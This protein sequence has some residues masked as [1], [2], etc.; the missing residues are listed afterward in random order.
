MPGEPLRRLCERAAEL[1]VPLLAQWEVTQR[2]NLGCRHCYLRGDAEGGELSTAEAVE[3]F[4]QMA[5]VGV[6]FLTFT[7]GEPLLRPDLFE[8]V[9]EARSLG[10]AWKLL[11][12][13][14]LVDDVTAR[15]I[16]ERAPHGVSVSLYGLEDA[17]DWMTTVPGSFRDTVGAIKR[18]VGLGVPVVAKM[19]LTPKGLPDVP[20]LRGLCTAMGV[21]LYISTNVYPGLA[22]GP[23]QDDL[24]LSD[25]ELADYL[26]EYRSRL[27][28][29][30]ARK[31]PP[32]AGDP[33]CNAG[34]SAFC[35]SP[36]GDVRACLFLR[37]V[38]GNCREA[39]LQ[40]IWHSEP[41]ARARGLTFGARAECGGCEQARF[42]SFCPG[43][44]E[45]ET[46]DALSPP[47]GACRE[48]RARAKAWGTQSEEPVP[49]G[50]GPDLRAG[51]ELSEP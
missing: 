49:G 4:R 25:G 18:L 27:E 1:A 12:N 15:D 46:G 13:A 16:A 44:A 34:R 37:R 20:A 29:V 39:P 26:A 8:L 17:H 47:P 45:A 22:G 21:R 33:I 11:T 10:F 23:A 38:C 40:D 41:M 19:C 7:G 14:T 24:K 48:A 43:R 36:R 3:L 28:P 50:A 5:R 31:S 32:D 42:C 35:V 30:L 9:D 2:C 51:C 6:M